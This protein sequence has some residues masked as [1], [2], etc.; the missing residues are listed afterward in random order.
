MNSKIIILSFLAVLYTGALFSQDIAKKTETAE[1]KVYG[2]CG[3]CKE[4]IENASLIKGVKKVEWN[5]ETEILK[6]IYNPQKVKIEDIHKAIA[7][8]GHDT[9]LVKADDK[10]YKKLPKCC[11]YRDSKEKH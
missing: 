6:V 1:F 3:S 9:D 5:K 7:S 11:A 2:L 10:V 8:V 4:R